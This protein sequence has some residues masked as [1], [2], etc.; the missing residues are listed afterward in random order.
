MAIFKKISLFFKVYRVS[1]KMAGS[2]VDLPRIKEVQDCLGPYQADKIGLVE[3]NTLDLGCGT[4]ARNPFNAKTIFGIDIRED[5]ARNVKYADLTTE[6][7]PY[8]DDHFDYVTAFDF[9]EH[10]P[11]IIYTPNR[12]FPFILLMNEIWR[13]LK[14]NGLFLSHTPIYPYTEVFRDPTHVNIFTHETFPF[15]F[16]DK[17]RAAQMYGFTGS[18]KIVGQYIK[19]PHLIS[20]LQKSA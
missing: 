14:P 7:I 16:D 6:P 12:Q 13:V 15:Y 10:I 9:L 4:Q 17:I 18:F 5:L 19:E 8:A 20:I 1:R 11:R 2:L 3:S